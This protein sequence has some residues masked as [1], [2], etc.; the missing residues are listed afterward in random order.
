MV[1][2]KQAL[3]SWLSIP[4]DIKKVTMQKITEVESFQVFEHNPYLV[5]GKVLTCIDHPN[6]D[7]LHITTVNV[8]DEVLPIVCGASNVKA[9]QTVIVA[10][11]GAL[12]PGDFLIKSAVI[13]GEKSE[14]MICSLKELGFSDKVISDAFKS[15]IYAFEEAL[16]PGSSAM[17]ALCLEGF[18]LELGLTPN[19][20]DLLSVYGF[21]LDLAAMLN[22][23]IQKPTY[24]IKY[25]KEKNPISVDIK[26]NQTPRY[27]ARVFKH[28][29]IKESPWWIQQLLIQNQIRPINNVVDITNYVLL[30]IGS[31]L[32]AFDYDT[33]GSQ[34]IV[35]RE[36]LEGEEVIT[37]D[38]AKR[39]LDKDD[40][41]ITNGK[42]VVA[43]GGVMGLKHTMITPQTTQVI[44]E[45]ALFDSEAIS[46]TSKRLQLRSD[47]SL[48]FERGVSE[49]QML[50][51]LELAT[52]LFQ[53]LAS[54]DVL[55]G[56]AF[57]V[58]KKEERNTIHLPYA[59][60]YD[61]LGITLT[62]DEIVSYLIR[63]Q[64]EVEVFDDYVV[65]KVPPI[66]FDIHE[67]VDLIEEIARMYGLDV[68]PSKPLSNHLKGG[69]THKQKTFKKVK[70]L[71]TSLGL[72]EVIS[73]SLR[74]EKEVLRFPS[75]GKPIGLMMP[76]SEDRKFLRQSLIPGML[77]VLSYNKKRQLDRIH[78]MEMGHVFYDEAEVEHLT[79]MMHGA[80]MGS[81]IY[82]PTLKPNFYVLKA[83]LKR[84]EQLF[85]VKITLDKDNLESIY[86]PYQ[87]AT[88]RLGDQIVGHIGALHPD[89]LKE[90]D[91]DDVYTLTL[92]LN[93]IYG[94][95]TLKS[96]ESMSKFPSVTRDLS[97]I[98]DA[99]MEIETPLALI[100]QTLKGYLESVHV[101]DIYQGENIEEG[102][103]SVACRMVLNDHKQTL[104]SD[105]VDKLMKKIIKRLSFELQIDIRS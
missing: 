71:L 5:V 63:Y 103:K 53:T 40:I 58:V 51:G 49:E 75:L 44:L 96:Y 82:G 47:A 50:L 17:E 76:L 78:V 6:S 42:E 91:L 79:I 101:F 4:E 64:Y 25:S 80:Y 26:S 87:S 86:H 29:V 19:R 41:V 95:H 99:Q 1:I 73:Y 39:R 66:R 27:H 22:Q 72:Q 37:L 93:L 30:M 89:V 9:G 97:M 3:K 2:T 10:K 68:I 60:V 16:E 92:N 13:R 31:P 54:A 14:G 28:V 55:E 69:Y 43:I 56:T 88:L 84:L 100:R 57:D 52:Y 85:H 15:G 83:F 18:S 59:L 11:P 38:D 61:Y 36:A 98:L 102:K 23:K 45:A 35:V 8:G 94:H 21:A 77:E 24:E 7:H 105:E 90:Y 65:A 104:E 32:H 67:P 46:K 20:N 81:H 70:H 34:H 74:K 33:F 12:L 48:R 62:K